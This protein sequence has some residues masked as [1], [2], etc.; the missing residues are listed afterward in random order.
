MKK[1]AVWRLIDQ[2]LLK[3]SEF[4]K[5]RRGLDTNWEDA[6]SRTV[7]VSNI[8]Y[9]HKTISASEM[10]PGYTPAMVALP[11]SPVPADLLTAHR[12][13]VT[14]SAL[15]QLYTGKINEWFQTNL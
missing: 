14:R 1:N 2:C 15:N 8:I 12:E 5:D 9:G 10:A 7:Y 6:L 4:F 3:D 13:K 11:K